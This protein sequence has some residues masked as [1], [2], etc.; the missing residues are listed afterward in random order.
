[1]TLLTSGNA[2][3]LYCL[4]WIEQF[5]QQQG[6]S[7]RILDVGCGRA[8]NFIE[9]LRRY[10]GVEYVG[11]E[12]NPAACVTARRNL[13]GFKATIMNDYAYDLMGR[14]VD[15][16]FDIVLSFSVFEHVY[17][18]QKYLNSVVDCL[19][20]DGYFLINYD[21]GHFMAPATLK[22][23]AKN[24]IG[25]WLAPLGIE[26]YYQRFVP[27]A[28]F[29]RM[30]EQAGLVVTEVKSFNTRLKGVHKHVPDA[31][32]EEHMQRWLDYELWLNELNMPYEDKDAHTWF[33]RNYILKRRSDT[34]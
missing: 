17:R 11:V 25:P 7:I 29:R 18:R 28:D 9:L 10:P 5:I 1:M 8:A 12:P 23:A 30:L 4:N 20:D 16:P 2:A 32:K 24:V 19:R 26:R 3:K 27:E 14:L 22:E 6:E 31:Y 21:A 13:D 15:A 33:T 34:R